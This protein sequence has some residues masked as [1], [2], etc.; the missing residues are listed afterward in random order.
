MQDP[1]TLDQINIPTYHSS[2]AYYKHGSALML[3]LNPAKTEL[4]G[5]GRKLKWQVEKVDV[6][7]VPIMATYVRMIASVCDLGVVF[8]SH[9]YF[10]HMD[11]QME[12][13]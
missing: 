12:D 11:R 13:T 5:W 1:G 2:T 7:D 8:N 6:L 10:L 9:T 3:R 4:K